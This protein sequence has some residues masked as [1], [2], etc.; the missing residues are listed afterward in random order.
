MQKA[1]IQDIYAFTREG[2]HSR[3]RILFHADI[4]GKE[5]TQTLLTA[6]KIKENIENENL[7]KINSVNK[8]INELKINNKNNKQCMQFLATRIFSIQITCAYIMLYCY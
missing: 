4:T 7:E 8:K 5:I 2:A 3:P 1:E 6:A